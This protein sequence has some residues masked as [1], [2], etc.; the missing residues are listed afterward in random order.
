MDLLILVVVLGCALAGAFAG[1]V[2][3]AAWLVAVVAAVGAG[4]WAGP[5]AAALM[6]G[7]SAPSPWLIAGGAVVTGAIAGGLVLLAGRGLRQAL[8]KVHLGC[9]DAAAGGLAAGATALALAAVLLALAG[10]SGYRP[11]GSYAQRLQDLGR[12]LLVLHESG[13]GPSPPS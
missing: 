12:D 11:A 1:L 5:A 13:G 4:R 9:L 2:R 3:L 6:A 8:K 10:Q 7:N